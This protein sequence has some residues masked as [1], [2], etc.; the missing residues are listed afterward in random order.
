[1]RESKAAWACPCVGWGIFSDKELVGFTTLTK[2][3]T[4][5]IPLVAV[6][7][8]AE[9]CVG[10]A[11][12]VSEAS[13]CEALLLPLKESYDVLK[14]RP[15]AVPIPDPTGIRMCGCGEGQLEGQEDE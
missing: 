9:G 13:G 4:E 7:A 11:S 12:E 1:M 8:G 15:G 3:V 6:M 10:N 14:V 5:V 2:G